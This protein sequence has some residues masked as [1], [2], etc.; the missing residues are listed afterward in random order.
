MLLFFILPCSCFNII[1]MLLTIERIKELRLNGKNKWGKALAHYLKPH[2][3][4]NE[5]LD[6]IQEFLLNQYAI[7][8]SLANL[9]KMKSN[10]YNK[11]KKVANLEEPKKV[12][13][14]NNI[15]NRESQSKFVQNQDKE[16]T[17]VSSEETIYDKI[18]GQ[19][20]RNDFDMNGL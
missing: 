5:R 11:P 15:S 10:Y 17:V 4:N 6:A 12:T 16:A 2:F 19:K 14:E 9:Q 1:C 3:D 18:Y 8:M 20:K 7:E 13:F